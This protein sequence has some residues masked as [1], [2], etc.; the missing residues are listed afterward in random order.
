MSGLRPIVLGSAMLAV[1]GLGSALGADLPVSPL[2]PPQ[3]PAVYIPEPPQFSWTGFYVGANAGYAWG[4]GSGSFNSGTIP[5]SA[6]ANAFNI[7]G[8]LGYNYQYGPA[9][10]GLE[11]DF[12]GNLAG[13][14]TL[15][16]AL[17]NVALTEPWFGTARAR[18]GYAFDRLMIYATGG[19]VYG[20]LGS[21]GTMAGTAFSSSS[22]YWTW[23][24][25]GGA[26][27]AFYGPWSAKIEYLYGGAP[28]SLP[29]LPVTNVSGS[30]STNLIRAG[31]DYHF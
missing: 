16:S 24:V 29:S 17:G 25:G 14:G 27:W 3:A 26:E 4:S 18:L 2:P 8:Q 1:S 15:S 10:F 20:R 19:G 21:N 31:L 28:S 9:V 23:T 5:F 11:G 22:N 6:T 13:T 12:Q 7:G 30:G